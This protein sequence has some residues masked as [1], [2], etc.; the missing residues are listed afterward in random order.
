MEP[1][2]LAP[3]PFRAIMLFRFLA[4][5]SLF[6]AAELSAAQPPITAVAFAP[7]GKSVVVGS[8]AGLAVYTWP[9]LS[10]QKSLKSSLPHIHDLAFSPDE[11]RLAVVGGQPAEVGAIELFSWPTEKLLF[12]TTVGEDLLYRA[13]W[14]GAG[15]QLAV[16]GPDHSIT[17]LDRS[18]G[19][20]GDVEGH[21][22]DVV[23]IAFLPDGQV[24][25]GSRDSTVRIWTQPTM[26]L[27][28]TLNNHT[29]EICD[30][31]VRPGS[32]EPPYVLA[33]SSLD[34]TVRF[35][36]PL[37]GRLMR[38]AKLPSAALDIEWTPEGANLV[39]AC[40]DGHLRVINPD[41]VQIIHDVEVGTGWLH[42]L[43]IAPDGVTAF[44]GG[45]GGLM[46]AVKI[47]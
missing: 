46:Q 25:S 39:A 36:W 42:S 22:R 35:W 21:S 14:Q 23:T 18:A 4:I 43:A 28:R 8:Q 10:K 13:A 44:V 47:R 6:V 27:V 11:S 12:R 34:R 17:L 5:L 16:A 24:V 32:S 7:D 38:F 15:D 29:N 20:V 37:K 31:A 33:S 26:K 40:A 1:L 45:S 2:I 19:V 41:T 9:A 30:L 3:L